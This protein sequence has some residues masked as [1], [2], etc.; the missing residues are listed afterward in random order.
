MEVDVVRA[1]GEV[2]RA[3]SLRLHAM[4]VHQAPPLILPNS[5]AGNL[6]SCHCQDNAPQ[7]ASEQCDR[8]LL[9]LLNRESGEREGAY[10]PAFKVSHVIPNP[11]VD[12]ASVKSIAVS[13]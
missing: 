12:A 13:L 2:D 5:L 3:Y 1:G 10:Q 4:V 6:R 7:A 9:D 11:G 8:S